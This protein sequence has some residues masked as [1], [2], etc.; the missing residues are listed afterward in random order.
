MTNEPKKTTLYCQNCLFEGE[1]GAIF[2]PICPDC[3]D[4]LCIWANKGTL[5]ELINSFKERLRPDLEYLIGRPLTYQN[6]ADIKTCIINHVMHELYLFDIH[7]QDMAPFY[8]FV[9]ELE[10]KTIRLKFL[11]RARSRLNL[12]SRMLLQSIGV[13]KEEF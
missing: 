10:P 7:V 4:R 5:T 12:Y 11:P 3:G 13:E 8:C 9:D 1:S 6:M 2:R